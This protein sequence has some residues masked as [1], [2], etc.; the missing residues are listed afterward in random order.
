MPS[1]TLPGAVNGVNP[2]DRGIIGEPNTDH[3]VDWG[4][5]A[6]GPLRIPRLHSGHDKTFWFASIEKFRQT[7]AQPAV[8]VPTE[9]IANGDFSG[10]VVPGETNPIPI[11]V[12]I[13]WEGDPSLMPAGCDPGAA[14]G[15]QFP[16]NVIP[17]NCFSAVSSRC[18]DLFPS[19]RL[20]VKSITFNRGLFHFWRIR[21]G[22]SPSTTISTP[23]RPF[24]ERTGAIEEQIAGGFVDNP[25]NNTTTNHWFGSGLL[26]TYSHA[27]TPRLMLSGG[28]SWI[29]ETLQLP[30]A[31]AHR[32]FCRRRALS[33]RGRVS[34]WNQLCRRSLASL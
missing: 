23:G 32:K 6:G 19:L 8:T 2:N 10:L 25:L 3:E 28:V 31:E 22:A 13:A 1:S 33:R 24:T 20:P 7:S 15:E 9:A 11:F 4:F 14:P 18:W 17:Q 16:G 30:S 12:P 27:I 34:P 29:T 26:V 5:T 21:F